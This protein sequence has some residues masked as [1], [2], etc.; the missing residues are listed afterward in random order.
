MEIWRQNKIYCR[1]RVYKFIGELL[2][3]SKKNSDLFKTI[4]N[5]YF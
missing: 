1:I 5:N 4:E 3:F 2:S